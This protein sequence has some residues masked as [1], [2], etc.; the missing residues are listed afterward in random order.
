MTQLPER[1]EHPNLANLTS[2]YAMNKE[3][4]LKRKRSRNQA[5]LMLS[6]FRPKQGKANYSL[7]P[8]SLPRAA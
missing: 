8:K 7:E 4:R 2:E 6:G 5:A 1:P 3:W